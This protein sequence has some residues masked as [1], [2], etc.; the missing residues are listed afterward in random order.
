M[1]DRL[2]WRPRALA[3]LCALCFALQL[4]AGDAA[5]PAKILFFTKS[6]RFE[7]SVIAQKDG[8]PSFAENILNEM[9]AKNNFT[10]TTT[11]DGSLITPDYL[12]KFD[13]I[14]FF[15]SGDLTADK[16]K[17]G[18]PPLTKEGKAALIDAVKNGKPFI[19][20][21]N[22]LKTFDAGD[23]NE[24]YVQ[25]LGGIGIGHGKIQVA[26]NTC[27]DTKFPGF[28]NLK[29]G[30]ELNEEWYSNKYFS[31]DIHVILVQQTTGMPDGV[32]LRPPFPATW[33]RKFGNGRVFVTGIGHLEATWSNPMFQTLLNGGIQ[34]ALGRVNADITPNIETVTPK[35]A[36]LPKAK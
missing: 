6:Q 25:M 1:I 10:I 20:V 34:W 27:V 18:S 26:K 19:C 21:H 36:E 7:H 24:P 17:D 30:V 12:A 16:S 4:F 8:K 15:T 33:A 2:D 14:M 22:G 9:G 29:D 3:S 23:E 32:Y 5:Q 28:E 11:K 31:K 13:A 35:Y